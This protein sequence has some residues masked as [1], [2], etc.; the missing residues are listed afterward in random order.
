MAR[1]SHR[2]RHDKGEIV[3]DV[4]VAIAN[5]HQVNEVGK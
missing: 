4:E 2:S 3:Y 5:D 1:L